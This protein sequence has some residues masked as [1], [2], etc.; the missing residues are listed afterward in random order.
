MRTYNHSFIFF[1]LVWGANFTKR[2]FVSSLAVRGWRGHAE[3]QRCTLQHH[4]LRLCFYGVGM[5]WDNG[6]SLDLP[7]APQA[8]TIFFRGE[9]VVGRLLRY[10][11]FGI[12]VSPYFYSGIVYDTRELT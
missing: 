3:G 8:G 6:C 1:L 11:R 7:G 4:Q 2:G 9:E 10:D 12:Q 5:L